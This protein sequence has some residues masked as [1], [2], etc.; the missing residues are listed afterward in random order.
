[1]YLGSPGALYFD[2]PSENGTYYVEE[3][4]PFRLICRIDPHTYGFPNISLSVLDTNS[5]NSTQVVGN[6]IAANVISFSTCRLS[7]YYCLCS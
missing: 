2:P 3:F 4:R 7:N 5:N 1:M 6:Y